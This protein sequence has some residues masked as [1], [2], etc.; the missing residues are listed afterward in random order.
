MVAYHQR[1]GKPK[2]GTDWRDLAMVLLTFPELKQ[3]HGLVAERLQTAG[4]APEV[5]AV[6]GDLVAQE[7]RLEGE[8]DEY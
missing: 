4:V 5:L 1:R 7:L 8:D 2:F 6:W 3:E